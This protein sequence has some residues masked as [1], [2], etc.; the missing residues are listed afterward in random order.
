MSSQPPYGSFADVAAGVP[1]VQAVRRL[2]E[3]V[4]PLDQIDRN[5]IVVEM[6]PPQ[7]EPRRPREHARQIAQRAGVGR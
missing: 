2:T 4:E 6:F 1:M 3:L 7:S 5:V